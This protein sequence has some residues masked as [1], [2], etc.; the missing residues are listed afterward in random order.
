[1][2]KPY[3][4]EWW[5]EHPNS[6]RCHAKRTNG[7]GDQCARPAIN[8]AVVCRK[9]GG[10]MEQVRRRAAERIMAAADDAASRLIRWMADDSVPIAERR[11]IAQDLLNRANLS[12]T[13][14]IEATVTAKWQDGIEGLLVESIDAP[15]KPKAEPDPYYFEKVKEDEQDPSRSTI[16]EEMSQTTDILV[17]PVDVTE[18]A[19]MK[20]TLPRDVSEQ[21]RKQWGGDEMKGIERRDPTAVGVD[22]H[23][24]RVIV[25]PERPYLEVVFVDDL[26]APTRE[27]RMR[28]THPYEL[29]DVSRP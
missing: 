2:S 3:S 4:E 8:G 19:S 16:S 17:V 13:T 22:F 9:H 23:L 15:A 28:S 7:S 24:Q 20:A 12:G 18:V 14:T 5:A 27:L 29:R 25:H 26:A 11:K 1:M 10:Q 6:V 21:Q